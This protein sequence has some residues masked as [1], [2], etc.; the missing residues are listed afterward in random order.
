M[1]KLVQLP[2][3]VWIYCQKYRSIYTGCM[4]IGMEAI[5]VW[6]SSNVN[7]QDLLAEQ[8]IA[9]MNMNISSFMN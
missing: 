7:Q 6:M 8:G 4:A 1:A 2:R 5:L 9:N 3:S